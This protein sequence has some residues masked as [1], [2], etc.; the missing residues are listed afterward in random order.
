MSTPKPMFVREVARIDDPR[1]VS[2][3]GAGHRARRLIDPPDAAFADPF[4]LMAED[5]TPP[6]IFA[7]HPHRGIGSSA[8]G[9]V[10]AG[11]ALTDCGHRFG[12]EGE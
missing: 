12:V 4:V 9:C 3:Q 1:F 8:D 7:F 2:G 10:R 11:V 5:W 6:G